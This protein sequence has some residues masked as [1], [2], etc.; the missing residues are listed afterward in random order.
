MTRNDDTSQAQHDTARKG[1]LLMW[2]GVVMVAGIL[3][4]A[5]A[6]GQMLWLPAL[7]AAGMVGVGWEMA[8]ADRRK[9]TR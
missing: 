1:R 4:V 3:F 8:K 7:I 9:V 2:L 6:K 5:V